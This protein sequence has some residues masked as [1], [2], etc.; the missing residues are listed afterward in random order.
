MAT[1]TTNYNLK[2][3]SQNDYYN[4]EDFNNNADTI[5]TEIKKANDKINTEISGLDKKIKA[6]TTKINQVEQNIGDLNDLDTSNKSNIVEAINEVK[7]EIQ[8][9]G[10]GGTGGN[11]VVKTINRS[12]EA[13]SFGQ[14]GDTNTVGS[15]NFRNGLIIGANNDLTN[16]YNFGNSFLFGYGNVFQQEQSSGSNN[17][18]Q[19]LNSNVISKNYKAFANI[20]DSFAILPNHSQTSPVLETI[21]NG[22]MLAFY[23]NFGYATKLEASGSAGIIHSS[24]TGA[25]YKINQSLVVHEG[26]DTRI[27]NAIVVGTESSYLDINGGVI[28]GRENNT[29]LRRC[30]YT[31]MLGEGLETSVNYQTLLGKYNNPTTPSRTDTPCIIL[32]NGISN[33]SRTNSFRVEG[34]QV[35]AKNY[36]SSGADYAEYFEWLDGNLDDED[37]VGYFVALEEDKIVKAKEGDYILGVVSATPNIIGNSF[38]EDWEGRFLTDEF[39][40]KLKKIYTIEERKPIINEE[41]DILDYETVTKDVEWYIESDKYDKE[42]KYSPRSERSEW[43]TIG[44]LGQL[45]VRDDGTC[46]V[47]GFCTT[48][49]EGIATYSDNGYRVIKRIN[50]NL[51]KIIFR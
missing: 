32:G 46:K 29:R 23:S 19:I 16:V 15:G 49:N 22:C 1:Y 41:G 6:N 13:D 11:N 26:L 2:K 33:T 38:E 3:P 4:V 34:D 9:G 42:R 10:G 25:N 24:K 14:L 28:V 44:M 30:N 7:S 17:P 20:E 12:S 8:A 50:D 27:D 51:I 36:N 21:M 35:Y 47:N 5:D 40:R 45:I 39:G 43:S 48:N 31:N 37:R 18:S